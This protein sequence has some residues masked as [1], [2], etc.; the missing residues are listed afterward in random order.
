MVSS[1][2]SKT[3]SQVVDELVS[4]EI[5]SKVGNKLTTMRVT[6]GQVHFS[7]ATMIVQD[8]VHG[9]E[10]YGEMCGTLLAIQAYMFQYLAASVQP[11]QTSEEVN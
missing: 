4:D 11:A 8:I 7:L 9:S 5:I 1:I 3:F 2:S 6:S 10:D